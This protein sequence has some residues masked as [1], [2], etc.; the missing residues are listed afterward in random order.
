V[1]DGMGQPYEP[2]YFGTEN[3]VSQHADRTWSTE[4]CGDAYPYVCELDGWVTRPGDLHAYSSPLEAW[5]RRS[6]AAAACAGAHAH[7]ATFADAAELAFVTANV[8]V[9]ADAW[10]GL[11][12]LASE[13]SF[14]WVTGEPYAWANWAAGE[15]SADT[16]DSDCVVMQG[17]GQWD[18]RPCDSTERFLC[19]AD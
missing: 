14:A 6:E 19:E 4:V 15:P 11:D 2:D 17:D 5:L 13:G 10:I 1:G 8:H 3:C 9:D 12:D 16:P 7:L 18:D